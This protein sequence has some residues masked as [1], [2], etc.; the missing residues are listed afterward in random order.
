MKTSLLIFLMGLS[1]TLLHAQSE[2]PDS[3]KIRV[4]TE[5]LK[6]IFKLIDDPKAP[7]NKEL[8]R[9]N[10]HSKTTDVGFECSYYCF[11]L[12]GSS[13]TISVFQY[14]AKTMY[15]AI[16]SEKDK[17]SLFRHIL[18][19]EPSIKRR[20]ARMN[21]YDKSDSLYS[22]NTVLYDE[23]KHNVA[24]TLNVPLVTYPKKVD[25]SKTALMRIYSKHY[26]TLLDP[27]TRYPFGSNCGGVGGGEGAEAPGER[28]ILY[29]AGYLKDTPTVKSIITGYN[30]EGRIYAIF[31]LL[32]M[33][34]NNEYHLTT[35]DKAL[36]NKVLDLDI[37]IH[38]CEGCIGQYVKGRDAVK[39]LRG[40][41]LLQLLQ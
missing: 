6:K 1:P 25:T 23:Y 31:Q 16:Q 33:A 15:Y 21:G 7:G 18:T 14:R 35:E 2:S 29:F 11:H 26:H 36:I 9:A 17:D 10:N 41:S 13:T 19:K 34:R 20:L 3:T 38:A 32:L 8:T 24:N 5:L 22:L 28:A 27:F 30:P 40:A 37:I 4:D 39:L 12:W